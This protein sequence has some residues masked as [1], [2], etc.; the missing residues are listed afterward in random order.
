MSHDGTKRYMLGESISCQTPC[1][2]DIKLYWG[3]ICSGYILCRLEGAM[4][5]AWAATCP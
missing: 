5:L 3:R 4:Q 1:N 2:K